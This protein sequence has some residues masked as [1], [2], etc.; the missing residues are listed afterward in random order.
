VR[1]PLDVEFRVTKL[2]DLYAGVGTLKPRV[3]IESQP[4]Y[5]GAHARSSMPWLYDGPVDL[6]VPTEVGF[7]I[8]RMVDEYLCLASADL[9]VTLNMFIA[10][11]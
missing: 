6:P 1:Q 2:V 5:I 3:C 8:S 7:D 9:A 4:V 10:I 11:R